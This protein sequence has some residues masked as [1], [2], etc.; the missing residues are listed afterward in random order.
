MGEGTLVYH[1][2]SYGNRDS[3]VDP[4]TG[5]AYVVEPKLNEEGK[6]TADRILVWPVETAKDK[7][8]MV[9]ARDKITTSRIATVGENREGKKDSAVIEPNNQSDQKLEEW[10]KSQYSHTET[11]FV[12][13]TWGSQEESHKEQTVV[14]NKKGQNMNREPLFDLNNGKLLNFMDPVYDEHGLVLYYQRSDSCYDKGTELYDRNGDFVRYKN[15]D[16]LEEYNRGAYALDG[17]D[18]LFDGKADAEHQIQDRLYHRLGE[19]YLLENS[20]ISSDKTPNDP[21]EEELTEGQPDLLK[22]L[23]AGTYIVEEL[24]VP[25]G[26][27]YTKAFPVGV[28]VE[29]E[30]TV[31]SVSIWDDTTK[32]YFEKID[33]QEGSGEETFCFTNRQMEGAELALYPAKKVS[34]PS[35]PDGWRLE[36]I[37]DVPFRFE[38]TNSRTGSREYQEMLWRTGSI[39]HYVEGMGGA[40]AGSSEFQAV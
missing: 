6:H 1:L 39:P 29:E 38:T 31:K 8:G 10:E 9:T 36:K 12:N 35:E 37:S 28:T 30:E 16:N 34:D 32:G 5:M 13:G 2:D 7:N 26:S 33:G 23:P 27:G 11:G 21:F 24:E 25:S 40:Y 19:S 22:R 17:H 15:S 18:K 20:W 4:Q 14:Q 3:L